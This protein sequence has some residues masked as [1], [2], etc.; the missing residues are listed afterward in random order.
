MNV[1]IVPVYFLDRNSLFHYS[2][3]LIDWRVRLLRLPAEVFN[4]H[5]KRTRI[6]IGNIITQKMQGT[7]EDVHAFGEYLRNKVYNLD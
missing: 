2:L 5:E 4:K 6:V 1:P 3:G 7:F